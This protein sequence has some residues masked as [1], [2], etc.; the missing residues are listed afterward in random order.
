[1]IYE[2]RATIFFT[3]LEQAENLIRLCTSAMIDAVVVKPDQP[4]QEGSTLEVIKCYH[5]ETPTKP[6]T[7]ITWTHPV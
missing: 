6:C 7:L 5:D 2:V 1:M 4:D 3:K